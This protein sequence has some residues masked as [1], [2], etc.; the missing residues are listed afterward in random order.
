MNRDRD[1]EAKRRKENR[2]KGRR[3]KGQE[4]APN[5]AETFYEYRSLT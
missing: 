5:R 2:P 1:S 3:Q 4:G